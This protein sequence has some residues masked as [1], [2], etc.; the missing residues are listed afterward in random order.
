MN[1]PVPDSRLNT[2]ASVHVWL[3]PFDD[4]DRADWT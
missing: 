2:S 3:T 1:S 4:F